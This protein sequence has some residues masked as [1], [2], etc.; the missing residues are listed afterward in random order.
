MEGGRNEGGWERG[1]K[2]KGEMNGGRKKG[3]KGWKE[4]REGGMKEE[5]SLRE[6]ELKRGRGE[7]GRQIYVLWQS[8]LHFL[9]LC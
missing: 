2:G 8:F 7:R 9:Y 5:G 3:M 1:R 6:A 4:G